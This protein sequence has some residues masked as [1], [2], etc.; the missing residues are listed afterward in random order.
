MCDQ[1]GYEISEEDF[2]AVIK[3]LKAYVDVTEQDLEKI[4]KIAIKHSKNRIALMTS[5]GEL[6]T[7]EVVSVKKDRTIHDLSQL[8]FEKKISGLPV[9]DDENHVIGMLTEADILHLAGVDKNHKFRDVV[10]CIIGELSPKHNEG[11]TAGDIMTSPAITAK[12]DD[13]LSDVAKILDQKGIKRLPVV[14]D[15]NKLIG[16][17]S[18]ADIIKVLG[19]L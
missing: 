3:E 19:T 9:V 10:R 5:V 6:M 15:E 13:H 4:Y 11:E 2:R 17:V 7:R 12:P 16:I 18:R 1:R 8:M 14:D